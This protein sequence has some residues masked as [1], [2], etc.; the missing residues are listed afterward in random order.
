[1]IYRFSLQG[2]KCAGCVSS[3]EKGLKSSEIVDDCSVNFADRSLS[4]STHDS[5]EAV[6]TV[7]EEAGYGAVEL[8]DNDGL[9]QAQIAEQ[10]H[11]QKTLK[12]SGI[13]LA[14]GFLL[15]LQMWFGAM[16]NI[17]NINGVIEGGGVG[18][19]SLLLM[20]FCAGHIYRGAWR[21]ALKLNFN[22]DSLVALGTGAAWVYS[23]GLLIISALGYS[24]PEAASHLYYEASVMIIGFILLGQ[25][26]EARA[27]KKTGDAVRNLMLL[28]PST[29]LRIKENS[30]ELVAV[31]LLSLGDRIRIRPGESIPVDGCVISGDSYL[32]ESM[33]TGES[34]AV[35]KQQGDVLVGGTING[36]GSMVM[37][38]ESIGSQTVLAQIIEAVREAQNSKPELGKLADKIAA[39]FVPVVIGI[40]LLTACIWLIYGPDPQLTYAVITMMTVLIIACPCALGLA[41]PMSVMVAVGRAASQGIL[42]R[43]ADALQ[44]AEKVTTV[45]VDKTG[46]VTQGEPSVTDDMYLCDPAEVKELQT[47]VATIE[48]YSEHPLASAVCTHMSDL[49]VENNVENVQAFESITGL[50]VSASTGGSAWI[51]GSLALMQRNDVDCESVFS[52]ASIW[53]SQAK[54]LVYVARDKK[55]VALFAITDPVKHD[56]EKAINELLH[57]G[58]KVVLLSGD[59]Q[60]TATA[61]AKQVGIEHVISEVKPEEKK[62]VIQQLQSEG[63]VVAMVGDGVNDAP[64]LAQA[65]LGYAI[66]TGSG[67]AIASADVTLISGSLLGVD[68]AMKISKATV[69]NIKQ[70][71]FGAFIY[72]AVS[73][74]VAAGI[75]FP[76]SG[77]LLNPAIAGAVMAM[78]SVTVVSNANRLRLLKV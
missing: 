33:L 44:L 46:T 24:L 36:S 27:R 45:V 68:K 38:V 12:R 57:S 13:A 35:H 50:G 43:N 51:I 55:L 26:L 7:V 59:N 31:E 28:S 5:V 52:K 41:T 71:L 72:N 23:T 18:F 70:N 32:D 21:S 17:S 20:Y 62:E 11:Y 63:E 78:S 69:R 74:P 48:S 65:D 3:L 1:M 9:E 47:I 39:Y 25:A 8:D 64:A 2:V 67:I 42:I 60:L 53:A 75:L 37:E 34:I 66:G 29:A 15:M 19:A 16:P 61:V 56:S 49:L 58:L 6:I 76:I 14:F 54:S 4:V 10:A 77:V 73:I 30:E 40:A 22:M